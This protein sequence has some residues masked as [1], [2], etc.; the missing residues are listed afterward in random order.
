MLVRFSQYQRRSVFPPL[1]IVG[2]REIDAVKLS[3]FL[4]VVEYNNNS[5][6]HDVLLCGA[7]INDYWKMINN[8]RNFT[9]KRRQEFRAATTYRA[10]VVYSPSQ[11]RLRSRRGH[12][13]LLLLL[14][15]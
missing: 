10:R 5:N 15:V 1:G 7:T 9:E 12:P 8:G 6:N 11:S 4:P 2:V 3:Y 13:S 14:L